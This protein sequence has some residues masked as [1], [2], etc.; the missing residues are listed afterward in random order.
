[1]MSIAQNRTIVSRAFVACEAKP[2]YKRAGNDL[3]DFGML[4]GSPPAVED[5][6]ALYDRSPAVIPVLEDDG[7]SPAGIVANFDK[8]PRRLPQNK[9][10]ELFR[11]YAGANIA[12][13]PYL[14]RSRLVVVDC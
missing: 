11:K 12:I 1:M 5:A 7:K 6:L 2:C 9:T 3:R 14:C 10:A 13:L 8:C 4:I